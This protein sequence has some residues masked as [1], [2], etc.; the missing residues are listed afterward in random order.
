MHRLVYEYE[1]DPAR[2]DQFEQAYRADGA[3]AGFF[4][5]GAGYLGTEL[6]RDPTRPGRYLVVDHWASADAATRFLAGHAE[7]YERRSRDTS[8]LYL[9]EARLGA[10]DVVAPA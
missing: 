10:F 3:W 8:R 4:R 1:V 5:G 7:E 2:V 6:L 9:V